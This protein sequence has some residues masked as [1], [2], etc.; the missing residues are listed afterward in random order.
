[1]KE[2]MVNRTNGVRFEKELCD[3]LFKRGW[4]SHNMAQNKDGQPADIIAVKSNIAVL[5]D[6]KVCENGTFPFTRVEENQENAMKVWENMGNS[7]AYFALKLK[8]EVHLFS[9]IRY[10]LMSRT[11]KKSLN[12]DDIRALPTFDEI[13]KKIEWVM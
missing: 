2:S 8:D 10:D 12:E 1:M 13:F 7:Y 3:Q 9:F 6:C 11:E 4:W 5:I